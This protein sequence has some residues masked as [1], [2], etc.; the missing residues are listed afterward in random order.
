MVVSLALD[1]AIRARMVQFAARPA[2][3]IYALLN[4]AIPA[5]QYMAEEKAPVKLW[6]VVELRTS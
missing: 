4:S 5:A 6:A 1:A 2:R 3:D